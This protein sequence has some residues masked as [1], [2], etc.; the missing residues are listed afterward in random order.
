[1]IRSQSLL[2]MPLLLALLAAPAAAT[3]VEEIPLQLH[4][5]DCGT[6]NGLEASSFLPGVEDRPERIDMVNRCYLVVHPKG[7]LLWDVGFSTGASARLQAW[8]FWLTSWGRSSIDPAAPLVTQIEAL[9][10][11][12]AQIDYLALSHV[13]FDHVGQ[14]S[15]FAGATWLVQTKEREWAFSPDL[16]NEA[17]QPELYEALRDAKTIHLD[18]D[19]DVFGD[20]SVEILSTPGH[21]PGHQ[22]LYLDLP[23]TGP[24]M[25]TGDL[26]HSLINR[27]K[28]VAPAFNVDEPQTQQS[29]ER[30]ERIA[31]ERGA[32]V[33]I[34]HAPQS[35]AL[36]PALLE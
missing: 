3:T 11:D 18:G 2:A 33:W 32:Q 28:R 9:G 22:S 4:V 29:M 21:T 23:Q 10:L 25:L 16:E 12:P 26:Y 15:D 1:M 17:V 35:G 30:F 7:T 34:Q 19:H 36:A 5:L 6:M 13:H 8:L 20:G 14:A 27:E 31:T 24:V